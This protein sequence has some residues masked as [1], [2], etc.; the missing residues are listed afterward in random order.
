MHLPRRENRPDSAFRRGKVLVIFRQPRHWTVF[1]GIS[2]DHFRTSFDKS[3]FVLSELPGLFMEHKTEALYEQV[4]EHQ[5][6]VGFT[7]P[8]SH[9]RLNREKRIIEF[10]FSRTIS[11]DPRKP[12]WPFHQI[13]RHSESPHD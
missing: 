10:F 7:R 9:R 4:L 5:L 3:Q 2:E 12:F 8:L 13:L 6:K 11:R 1:H